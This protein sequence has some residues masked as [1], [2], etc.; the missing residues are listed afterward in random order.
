MSL[1]LHPKNEKQFMKSIDLLRENSYTLSSNWFQK[2][3]LPYLALLFDVAV[4]GVVTLFAIKDFLVGNFV[5][6][7]ILSPILELLILT[8]LLFIRF[9]LSLLMFSIK[10]VGLYCSIAYIFIVMFLELQNMI[11]IPPIMFIAASIS[12]FF[13]S[14]VITVPKI[15][16]DIFIYGL[17]IYIFYLPILF[18]LYYILAKKK[19]NNNVSYFDVLTGFYAS[20]LSRKLH[21]EDVIVVVAQMA[22]AV[23]IGI[24]SSSL[25][26]AFV[27]VA[28]SSYSC[29]DLIKKFNLKEH[30]T[31]KKKIVITFFSML[32]VF[33]IIYTQRLYWWGF[34]VFLLCVVSMY[35]LLSVMTKNYFKSLFIVLISFCAI[36]I[37]ILGYN[38]FAHPQIAVVFKSKPYKNEEVFYITKNRNGLL[39]LRNRNDRYVANRY[40]NIQH[41]QKDRILLIRPN[42]Q[43]DLYN[44]GNDIIYL[45]VKEVF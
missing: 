8:V 16:N 31:R 28:L 12:R 4:I 14:Y 23:Y 32:S 26:W 1:P 27:A 10:R 38:I 2:Y 7:F 21:I 24:L 9:N 30:M 22:I 29:I 18:Y 42:G 36:P 40:V 45:N 44:L 37:F 17:Y 25:N 41:P 33:L 3:K 43:K 20:T 11:T 19:M 34:V 15:V 13:N 5:Q 39:G 6:T 35:L